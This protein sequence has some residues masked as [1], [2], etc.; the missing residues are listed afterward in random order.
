MK[1]EPTPQLEPPTLSSASTPRPQGKTKRWKQ[2][3]QAAGPGN[4]PGIGNPSE[5]PIQHLFVLHMRG[6][7]S[8]HQGVGVSSVNDTKLKQK[9]VAPWVMHQNDLAIS[10]F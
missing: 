1:D 4:F 5:T 3:R 10:S 6:F 8:P 2:E 7:D 9:P